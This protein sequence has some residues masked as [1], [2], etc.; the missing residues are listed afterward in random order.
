[1]PRLLFFG[2]LRERA[3]DLHEQVV[4][5]DARTL[6]D[7]VNWIAKRNPELGEALKAKGVRV[8]IDQAFAS[9]DAPVGN[10]KEIAFMSPLSG[11]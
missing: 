9:L 3:G 2:P 7:V 10:A 4:Q 11:G 5:L 8:A 6:A 1:M